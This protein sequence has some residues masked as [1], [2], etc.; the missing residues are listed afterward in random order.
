LIPPEKCHAGRQ[1]RRDRIAA[2]LARHQDL[3]R[4]AL[5]NAELDEGGAEPERVEQQDEIRKSHDYFP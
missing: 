5:R 2:L 1:G 4:I 3:Q